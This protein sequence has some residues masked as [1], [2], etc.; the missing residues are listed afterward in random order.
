VWVRKETPRVV[1]TPPEPRGF[2]FVKAGEAWNVAIRRVG[3]YA[4]KGTH[5]DEGLQHNPNTHYFICTDH[6]LNLDALNAHTF[7][8]N[9]TGPRSLSKGEITLV[10]NDILGVS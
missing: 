5:H 6:Q 9:T 10:L 1:E 7:P 2:R 4:G 8:T 3:V